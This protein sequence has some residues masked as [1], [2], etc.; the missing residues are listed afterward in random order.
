VGDIIKNYSSTKAVI[1]VGDAKVTVDDFLRAYDREKQRIKNNASTPLSDEEMKHINIKQI[2][3]DEM[4]QSS[5]IE[6]AIKKLNITVSQKTVSDIVR[7]LPEF[8]KNGS[9]DDV[10]YE[11]LLH[12]SGLSEVGFL[13]NIRV[14]VARSQMFSTIASG[15]KAPAFIKEI[16]AKE[17]EAKRDVLIA[18]ID[19]NK[20]R[21][22]DKVDEDTLRQFYSS[23]AEKYKR[24]ETRNAAVLILNYTKFAEDISVDEGEVQRVYE[25]TKDAYNIEETRDFDR[26]A[27]GNNADATTAWKMLVKGESIEKISRKLMVRVVP[28]EGCRL[29]DFPV[30]VGK[31]L[32]RIKKGKVSS[33]HIVNGV[34]YIYKLTNVNKAQRKSEAEIKEIIS[35]ELQKE[36]INSLEFE[37]KA[38][39]IRARVDDSLGADE[40]IESIA[41]ELGMRLVEI[42]GVNKKE[43]N[44]KLSEIVQDQE[45]R[46]DVIDAIFETDERQATSIIP[47]R[48]GDSTEYVAVVR[49]ITKEAIPEYESV[50]SAVRRD[51]IREKKDKLAAEEINKILAKNK[52]AAK[53]VLKIPTVKSFRFSKMDVISHT[54]NPS[55]AVE[56]ALNEIPNANVILN[57][58]STLGQ[59][60]AIHYKM[61]DKEYAIIA[62]SGVKESGMASSDASG[63]VERYVDSCTER[64]APP[65]AIDAFKRQMKVKID[66]ERIDATEK[67]INDRSGD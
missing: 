66:R 44:A 38:K 54:K 50:N 56:S 22:N 40:P 13:S 58:I 12:R 18:K 57:A 3:I 34:L 46:A 21:Y 36:K 32:F 24:P 59:G 14:R 33:I 8:Q 19:V 29:S 63:V 2:V 61:S 11:S 62:V 1:T 43:G 39:A 48:T 42:D 51:F 37:E 55:P 28:L 30:K 23:N 53:E 17:F 67:Q 31:D 35:G 27:F 9:F 60:E 65:I 7:S 6:Q 25:S 4:I 10:L 49:K 52:D 26:F 45:T 16:M 5:V 47:S 41:K 20:M 15:Y 64:D